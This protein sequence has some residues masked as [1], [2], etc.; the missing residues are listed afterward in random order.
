M[1]ALWVTASPLGPSARILGVA[2]G[3]SGG[4]VQTIYEETAPEKRLHLDFLCFSKSV[5][6]GEIRTAESAEGE[7]VYCLN[8]PGVPFGVEPSE[9]LRKQVETVIA[10]VK[11][12]IIQIWGT[13]TVVQ[14]VVASCAAH[15]PKVVFLQGLIGVHARY[16]GGRLDSIG[17]KMHRRPGELIRFLARKRQFARQADFE[18]KELREAERIIIDND[19]LLSY[20]RSV[21]PDIQTYRYRLNPNRIFEQYEWSIDKCRRHRIF[22]VFGGGPDKGLHQLIRAAAIVKES[23]PDLQIIIPGVFHT[24]ERGKL[25]DDGVLS[26]YERFM[27]SLIK[28]LNLDD[29]VIFCGRMSPEGMAKQLV[30][31]HCFVNPSVMETHAGS[32]REAMTVGVPSV[33][34][35]CGS[36]GEFLQEGITG[37]LY[38][39]EEHEVLAFKLKK[40]FDDNELAV[41]AGKAAREEMRLLRDAAR[42]SES[43]FGIYNEILGCCEQTIIVHGRIIL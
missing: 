28:K 35:Y 30:G 26:P 25:R 38:R 2:A 18:K 29:N 17:L 42:R 39:Y 5:K 27:K 8:M 33:S 15:I 36:V 32:L 13:E 19:F 43:L 11:P 23:F 24:D 21:K 37:W 40:L 22:T 10:A 7:K 41:R 1:K 12:D 6:R 16:Y 3:T 31:S 34:T 9:T 14:N 4:W 20:C